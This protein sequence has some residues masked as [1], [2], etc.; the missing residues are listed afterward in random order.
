MENIEEFKQ[1][2]RSWIEENLPA[3]LRVGNRKDLPGKPLGEWIN[4][5]VVVGSRPSGRRST[6][7]A[8]WTAS[9]PARCCRN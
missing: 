2:V 5:R 6:A 9:K 1:E 7:A 3:E 4:A 8:G